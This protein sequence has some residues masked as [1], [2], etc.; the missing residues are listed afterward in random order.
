MDFSTLPKI[1]ENS[2]T[3]NWLEFF[4]KKKRKKIFL[5]LGKS[6]FLMKLPP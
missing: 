5:I 3:T 1:H 4:L 2:K 6:H